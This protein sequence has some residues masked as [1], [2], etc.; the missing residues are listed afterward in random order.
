MR[1]A[2]LA[3]GVSSWFPFRL[4]TGTPHASVTPP[5]EPPQQTCEVDRSTVFSRKVNSFFCRFNY[6]NLVKVILSYHS[7]M[8]LSTSKNR[9]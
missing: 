4:S 8:F 2:F 5:A 1:A 6:R 7:C 9:P 3:R